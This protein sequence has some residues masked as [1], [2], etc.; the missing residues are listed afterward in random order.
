[1]LNAPSADPQMKSSGKLDALQFAPENVTLQVIQSKC[2]P[3]LLYGLDA[4]PL[5]KSDI[6]RPC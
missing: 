1:M 3:A 2:I 6:D 4:F 5:N